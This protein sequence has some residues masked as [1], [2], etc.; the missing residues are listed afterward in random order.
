MYRNLVLIMM[1]VILMCSCGSKSEKPLTKEG[2]KVLIVYY[3]WSGNTKVLASQIQKHTGGKM[4]EIEMEKPYT[5]VYGDCVKQAREEITKGVKPAIK[6]KIADL[7]QYDVI[8][9]GSPNWCSTIAPPVATFLAQ[10]DLSGKTVA[11]FQ[12]HGGG[13][14]ANCE[15]DVK[16][17]CPKAT[18]LKGLSVD[19]S[20]VTTSEPEVVKWLK[21]VDIID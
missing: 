12:T 1:S 10:N 4:V 6:T 11:V 17:A 20:N 2:K 14:M 21:E 19:G 7:A 13:G 9:I 3:T 8:L 16:K 5:K 15:S 18:F